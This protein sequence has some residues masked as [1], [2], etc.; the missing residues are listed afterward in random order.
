MRLVIVLTCL[1]AA[2]DDL[3]SL[4]L[5]HWLHYKRGTR[6]ANFVLQDNMSCSLCLCIPVKEH[7]GS[8]VEC[9]TQD[10]GAAGSSL[11]VVTVLCP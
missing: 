2:S 4:R 6:S 8:V 9:L 5:S 1:L 10:R 7:S 3:I 11:T